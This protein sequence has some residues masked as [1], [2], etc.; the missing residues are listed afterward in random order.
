[1]VEII[2][3]LTAKIPPP[4]EAVN[5]THFQKSGDIG[6]SGDIGGIFCVSSKGMFVVPQGG[7]DIN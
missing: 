1:M 6:S 5:D 3:P 2:Y 7:L 4:K